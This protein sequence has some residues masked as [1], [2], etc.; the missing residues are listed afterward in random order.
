M[1]RTTIDPIRGYKRTEEPKPLTMD[2]QSHTWDYYIYDLPLGET[3]LL[4]TVE[5]TA[6]EKQADGTYVDGEITKKEY[7]AGY[8]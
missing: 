7:L 8:H 2:S 6:Q 5:V 3:E 4:F 1:T